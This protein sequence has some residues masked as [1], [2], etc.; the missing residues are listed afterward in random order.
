M[1][2][3]ESSRHLRCTVHVRWDLLVVNNAAHPCLA[4]LPLAVACDEQCIAKHS[5]LPLEFI[6]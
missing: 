1:P 4:G 5:R 6:T 3:T 2:P